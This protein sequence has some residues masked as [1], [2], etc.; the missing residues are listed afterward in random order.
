MSVPDWPR[1]ST[2]TNPSAKNPRSDPPQ[3]PAFH[4]FSIDPP[5]SKRRQLES[6]R[7]NSTEIQT[8]RQKNN[9]QL[10][11]MHRSSGWLKSV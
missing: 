8:A 4:H 2:H 10:V 6:T 1:V 3:P 5:G 7:L 11:D 9:H